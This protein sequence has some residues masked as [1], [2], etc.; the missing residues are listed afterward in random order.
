MYLPRSVSAVPRYAYRAGT[1]LFPINGGLF[2]I[3]GGHFFSAPY[4][5]RIGP[6]TGPIQKVDFFFRIGG[7]I[8]WLCIGSV[9]VL[10]P[11]CTTRIS[12]IDR[13]YFLFVSCP[14]LAQI[15]VVSDPYRVHMR[16]YRIQIEPYRT[17]IG[18]YRVRIVPYWIRYKTNMKE[19]KQHFSLHT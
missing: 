13:W 6:D 3:N 1:G 19:L 10:Y 14:Y 7:H 15:G 17:Q 5:F 4:R 9:S 12:H 8:S 2:P 18:L 11:N 16:L